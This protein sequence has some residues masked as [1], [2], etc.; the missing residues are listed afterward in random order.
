[1]RT[2]ILA[3]A[4]LSLAPTCPPSPAPPPPPAPMPD[5]GP[6]PARDASAPSG[7]CQAACTTLHVLA[8]PEGDNPFACADACTAAHLVIADL[9]P[10]C[11]AGCKS[12]ACVRGCS[13][14]W[15]CTGR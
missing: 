10:R 15:R 3:V 4:L 1:M 11:V 9:A 7:D 2:L 14:S 13:A 12:G 6:I 8:C 5:A